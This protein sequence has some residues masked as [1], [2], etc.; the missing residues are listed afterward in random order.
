MAR[1]IKRIAAEADDLLVLDEPGRALIRRPDSGRDPSLELR[2]DRNQNP[3]PYTTVL[4]SL[5]RSSAPAPPW[6]RPP[7]HEFLVINCESGH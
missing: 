6:T 5:P 2:A 3:R 1:P 7:Q 4:R